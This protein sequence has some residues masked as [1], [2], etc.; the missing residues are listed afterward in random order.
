[1]FAI[2]LPWIVAGL[3]TIG[4]TLYV[5]LAGADFGGGVW[6]LLAFGPRKDAQREAIAKAMGPVWEANHVWLIFV[7]VLLFTAFPPAFAAICTA[8]AIPLTLVTVGIVLRGASFVFRAHAASL[9]MAQK[10]FG[11]VFGAASVITPIFL[12]MCVG[13]LGSGNIRF[14]QQGHL[15]TGY[16]DTWLSP[17]PLMIGILALCLCAFLAAVYLTLETTGEL[18]EDFRWRAVFS[19]IVTAL[20]ATITLPVTLDG[21]P[22]LWRELVWGR[23]TP[24]VLA[25]VLL[26]LVAMLACYFRRYR[27]ARLATIAEVAT[28][29]WGWAIAQAPALVVPDITI[30]G[31]AA[32]DSALGPQLIVLG[33]GSL[34]LLPSLWLLLKVFKGQNPAAH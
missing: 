5:I 22:V 15:L 6:D 33:L 3:M 19:G 30:K 25:T 9:V 23:A 24:L 8:L 2:E 28:I 4:L 34:I 11:W 13:A 29:V 31:S 27:L 17:F 26:G 20:I 12:G 14:N 32:P 10:A 16:F 1:M 7:I 21:A 18:R